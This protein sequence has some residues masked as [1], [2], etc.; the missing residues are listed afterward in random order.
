MWIHSEFS[1]G[2]RILLVRSVIWR[3]FLCF[4]MC[5][6]PRLNLFYCFLV[7]ARDDQIKE[8]KQFSTDFKVSAEIWREWVNNTKIEIHSRWTC[9]KM[10][11]YVSNVPI[12]Q[13]QSEE[14][15]RMSPAQSQHA[16]ASPSPTT[17]SSAESVSSITQP[18]PSPQRG[19]SPATPTAPAAAS[20]PVS[21]EDKADKEDEKLTEWVT[22]TFQLSACMLSMGSRG[23]LFHHQSEQS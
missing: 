11:L 15:K 13:L 9:R 3:C 21:A 19:A 17:P 22:R 16:L 1:V 7:A 6:K 12:A 23:T 20:P 4:V 8:L 2:A 10:W 5:C 14:K 18:S